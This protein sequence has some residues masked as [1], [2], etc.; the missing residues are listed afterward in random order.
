MNRN[1]YK[2]R[3]RLSDWRLKRQL[4]QRGLIYILISIFGHR[5]DLELGSRDWTVHSC[6]HSCVYS[7]ASFCHLCVF[8]FF[9][10]CLFIVC[11]CVNKDSARFYKGQG[12]ESNPSERGTGR[13]SSAEGESGE[14]VGHPGQPLFQPL[15]SI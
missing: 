1:K 13:D 14:G 10:F 4:I 15:Y 8:Y 9:F 2:I 7:S 12:P 3:I 11:N 5:L 6:V